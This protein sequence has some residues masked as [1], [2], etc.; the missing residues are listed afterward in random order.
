MLLDGCLRTIFTIGKDEDLDDLTSEDED[1]A[2]KRQRG[3]ALVA[4]VARSMA[5]REPLATHMALR[6]AI[7]YFSLYSVMFQCTSFAKLTF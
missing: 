1:M 4:D 2:E 6:Y 5:R 3:V 7:K